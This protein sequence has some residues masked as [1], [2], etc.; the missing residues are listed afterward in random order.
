MLID[1]RPLNSRGNH[2]LSKKT[3]A[4]FAMIGLAVPLFFLAFGS[5]LIEALAVGYFSGMM[6]AYCLIELNDNRP[7]PEWRS[8]PQRNS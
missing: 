3:L 1:D 4:A 5:N 6:T 7:P 8:R 2:P